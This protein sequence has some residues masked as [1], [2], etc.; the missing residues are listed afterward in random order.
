[1]GI[2]MEAFGPVSVDYFHGRRVEKVFVGD[3]N[4]ECE[5]GIKFE[6]GG[7]V[8]NYNPLSEKPPEAIVGLALTLS[9]LGAKETIGGKPGT[10]LYFGTS[11]NP[12][13]YVVLLD[14][15]EYAISDDV[16][17]KG[18]LVY[19]QRSEANMVQ[20]QGEDDGA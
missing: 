4:V 6:G 11:A 12:R 16:F 13:Q 8:L 10:L 1:M 9:V 20:A 19:A 14:P 3:E 2:S 15:L 18:Q 17:T 7:L 5:W